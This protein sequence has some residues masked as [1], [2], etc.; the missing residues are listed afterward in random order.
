MTDS[1]TFSSSLSELED[2]S[3]MKWAP[4]RS[5]VLNNLALPLE[6]STTAGIYR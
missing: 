2:P 6:P 1:G 3:A 5:K 4:V